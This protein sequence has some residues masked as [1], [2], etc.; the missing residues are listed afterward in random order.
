MTSGFTFTE[1]VTPNYRTVADLKSIS[2]ATSSPFQTVQIIETATFGKTLVLDGKTQSA[3]L[4]EFAYH[5]CLVHPTVLA[6]GWALGDA[7]HKPTRAFIG[8]GGEL[9][10]A[11][12]L[13]RH[14]S[15]TEVVMVDLDPLV[16]AESKAYLP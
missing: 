2:V 16:V 9:A 1:E 4:D 15:L 3:Q 11:R 13:L 7:A 14:A 6:V 5:E 8:G 12:E 10:T